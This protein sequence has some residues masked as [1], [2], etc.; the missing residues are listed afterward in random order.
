VDDQSREDKSALHSLTALS[1]SIMTDPSDSLGSPTGDR[2]IATAQVQ[3]GAGMQSLSV[4]SRGRETQEHKA[5]ET[6]RAE[7][8]DRQL[9]QQMMQSM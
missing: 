4:G 2:P 1:S 7:L 6:A 5:E 9:I 3:A 8:S